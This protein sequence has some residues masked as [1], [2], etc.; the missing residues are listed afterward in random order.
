MQAYLVMS[1]LNL[2]NVPNEM[3]SGLNDEMLDFVSRES[4]DRCVLELSDQF[5]KEL[6]E[7]DSLPVLSAAELDELAELEKSN[8]PKST[9]D[10][11]RRHVESFRKFLEERHLCV[12]RLKQ[13]RK[14][15]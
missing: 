13:C 7:T 1:L 3:I 4:G 8:V 12:R 14:I 2:V 9:S 6:Q 10:Q 11:T 5:R 15:S